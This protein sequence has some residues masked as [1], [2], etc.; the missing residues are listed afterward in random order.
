MLLA[1]PRLICQCP[2]VP[3]SGT[4][5]WPALPLADTSFLCELSLTKLFL[6]PEQ[7]ERTP[8][9]S[10]QGSAGVPAGPWLPAVWLFTRFGNRLGS[11]CF[12]VAGLFCFLWFPSSPNCVRK[13]KKLK[14]PSEIAG[15]L[16]PRDE[17]CCPLPDIVSLPYSQ[18]PSYRVSDWIL[19][20]IF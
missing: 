15:C 4:G 12:R 13:K 2:A 14:P 7:A 19:C 20:R 9:S 17:K 6:G 1:S 18:R 11:D 5:R 3:S 16:S 10:D 8:P